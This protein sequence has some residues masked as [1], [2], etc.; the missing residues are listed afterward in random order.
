MTKKNVLSASPPAP[1]PLRATRMVETIIGCK[2]SLTILE[3]MSRGVRRPGRM[4]R[5]VDG[6]TTKVLNDCLR[7]NLAFGIIEKKIFNESPPRVEYAFTAFGGEFLDVVRAVARLQ[8]RIEP[9]HSDMAA[10]SVRPPT[11]SD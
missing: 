5:E 6:L 3:L 8:E 1:A 11:A 10:R 7:K 2:W 9:R 4:V